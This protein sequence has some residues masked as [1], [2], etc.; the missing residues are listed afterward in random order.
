MRVG[1][2]TMLT[3]KEALG[4]LYKMSLVSSSL[5]E[6]YEALALALLLGSLSQPEVKVLDEDQDFDYPVSE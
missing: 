2:D 4:N 1:E 3:V 5:A 6:I